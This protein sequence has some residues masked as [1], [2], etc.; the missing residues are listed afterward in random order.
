MGRPNQKSNCANTISH[1]AEFATSAGTN[2]GRLQS[3]TPIIA[4]C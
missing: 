1:I 4:I 2:A 3:P